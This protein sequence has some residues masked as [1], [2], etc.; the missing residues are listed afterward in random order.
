ME[1]VKIEEGHKML[2]VKLSLKKKIETIKTR[3]AD[4]KIHGIV[5]INEH[6]NSMFRIEKNKEF[7]KQTAELYLQILE[8][9]LKELN[10]K[11]MAL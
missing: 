1:I 6:E 7:V 4:N 11:I 10:L 5:F 9:T 3:L 2:Q 8:G